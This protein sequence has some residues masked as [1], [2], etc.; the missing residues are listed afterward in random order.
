MLDKALSACVTLIREKASMDFICE[1]CGKHCKTGAGLAGHKM[2]AHPPG[3]QSAASNSPELAVAEM[4]EAVR[5]AYGRLEQ[6]LGEFGGQLTALKAQLV[7]VDNKLGDYGIARLDEGKSVSL[8]EE[9]ARLNDEVAHLNSREHRIDELRTWSS[10]L[11][12]DEYYQWGIAFGHLSAPEAPAADV[13]KVEDDKKAQLAEEKK[14]EPAKPRDTMDILRE[15][16]AASSSK[17]TPVVRDTMTIL[18]EI[19]H[20]YSP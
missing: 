14:P 3:S 2:M 13:A 9:N 20:G 1:V 12:R 11:T 8:K 6:R 18:K 16:V 5:D 4:L 17:A 7:T 19:A 10:R 15:L